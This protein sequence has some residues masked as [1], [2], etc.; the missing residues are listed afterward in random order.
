[1]KEN[2][3]KNNKQEFS[4]MT[5][6]GQFYQDKK[7]A[8]QKLLETIKKLNT[9]D[10]NKVIGNYK[11]F[12]FLVNYDTFDNKFIFKLQKN[13]SYSINLSTDY[14][15]NFTRIDNKLNSIEELLNNFKNK[16]Q[17]T[18]NQLIQAKQDVNRPFYKEDLL[19]EKTERLKFVE[20]K[21]NAEEKNIKPLSKDKEK[22][23][24]AV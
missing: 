22:L 23:E 15:G 13:H 1:M 19:K 11:G 24:L 9:F 20:S 2:S 14:Y 16:L 4:G 5:I 8:G 12:D 6:Q 17:E 3:D 7:E 18:K 21:I 10:Y